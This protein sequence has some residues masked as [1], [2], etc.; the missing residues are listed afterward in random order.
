VSLARVGLATAQIAAL[1]GGCPLLRTLAVARVSGLRELQVLGAPCLETLAVDCPLLAVL[2]LG[3][4]PALHTLRLTT[5][6]GLELVTAH[7]LALRTLT[8]CGAAAAPVAAWPVLCPVRSACAA[9]VGT[10]D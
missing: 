7:P 1:L 6:A 5:T 8:V 4:L 3:H 9:V 10:A 2:K